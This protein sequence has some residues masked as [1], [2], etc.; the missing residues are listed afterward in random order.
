M[1]T[2]S[3]PSPSSLPRGQGIGT[4]S[5]NPLTIR[6]VLLATSPHFCLFVCLGAAQTLLIDITKHVYGSHHLGIP[7]F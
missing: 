5:S 1:V 6:F 3:T 4:E 2:D 7:V